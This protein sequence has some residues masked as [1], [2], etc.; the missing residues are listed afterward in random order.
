MAEQL[1][2]HYGAEI[3]RRI[4]T[5]ISAVHPAFPAKRFLTTALAGYD[6][7]NLM[8]RGR[9]IAA[10]LALH[11]P[12]DFDAAADILLAS[13]GPRPRSQEGEGGM[14]SFLYLPHTLF[15]ASHGLD[16]FET[17]MRAQ[18]ELTQRFTAEFSM[19]PFLERHEQATL[20]RL[21]EWAGD[22]NEHV[23]RLV[24]EATR[25]RLPWAARL[26]RFQRDPRPVL[27][28]L[29]LLKDDP[30]LYVRRSV[31]NNLNDIGKDNPDQLIATL[32]R[33]QRQSTPERD[34]L[35]NHALRS[36][37]K[38]GEAPALEL[39]G[40]ADKPEVEVMDVAIT[41]ARATIGGAVSIGFTLRNTRR[42]PQQLLVDFRIHYRKAN[43]KSSPKVFKL[44]RVELAPGESLRLEK[45]VSLREMTTRRHYPGRHEVDL[46]VNG[47][48]FTL[49]SFSL[50][51]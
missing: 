51:A 6:E 2:N 1:R 30:S 14:A 21:A 20:A 40:F 26:R 11:L 39:L 18:Y 47:A 31:A 33:W 15:V 13:L 17:S 45:S 38:R 29:E 42:K 27:A 41:P 34:W 23:R 28:L 19:R 48:T 24:S 8:A 12:E 5:M 10:A 50:R 49:G 35:I 32:K 22:A 4:A 44:R 25:P 43:G 46:V 7:L 9:Q 16:H 37:I 36:A 3:P